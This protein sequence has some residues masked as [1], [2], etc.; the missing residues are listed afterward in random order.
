MNYVYLSALLDIN[1]ISFK[2]KSSWKIKSNE[3]KNKKIHFKKKKRIRK[4]SKPRE[5]N[6]KYDIFPLHLFKIIKECLSN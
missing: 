1:E 4:S 5:W 6:I 3:L 2:K